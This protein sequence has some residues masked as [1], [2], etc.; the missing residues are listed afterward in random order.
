MI[1]S[2]TRQALLRHLVGIVCSVA[3]L[4]AASVQSA[5]RWTD[6]STSLLER[7]TNSGSKLGYPGGCS[8]VVANRFNGDVTMKVV[9]CGLWRSSDKCKSW[10]RIDDNNISGK[11]ETGWATSVDQNEPTRMASFSLDGSAGWTANGLDWMSFTSLGRNWD[12][13]SVDWLWRSRKL[14]HSCSDKVTHPV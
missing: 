1:S 2:T 9:G 12:F 4:L 14:T 8:G 3:L 5:D 7:L 13:G 10:R 6:V 11:D